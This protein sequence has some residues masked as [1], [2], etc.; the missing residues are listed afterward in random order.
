MKSPN[1]LCFI[2]GLEHRMVGAVYNRFYDLLPPA[3]P[4]TDFT[5]QELGN[6][7]KLTTEQRKELIALRNSERSTLCSFPGLQSRTVHSV[8]QV[9]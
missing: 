4:K 6:V 9:V 7:Y 3:G 1:K 8:E 2:D 5:D